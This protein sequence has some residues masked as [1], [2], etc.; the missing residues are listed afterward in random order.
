LFAGVSASIRTEWEKQNN[1]EGFD[2]DLRPNDD[3][4]ESSKLRG[5]TRLSV[6]PGLTFDVPRLP[7]QRI[8]VEVGIPV[9]QD[10]DGPQLE[11]DWT[12]KTGWQWVY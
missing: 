5:G 3:P 11:R 2:R 9:Y 1:S 10:L 7:G 4:S 12:I 8:A 6:A